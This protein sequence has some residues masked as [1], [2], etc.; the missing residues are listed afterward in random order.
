MEIIPITSQRQG[1]LLRQLQAEYPFVH[2]RVL[3]RT[4]GGREI[5]ALQV[6]KGTRRVL[7]TAGHHAN[8]YI[9]SMM[10]WNILSGYCEAVR[11]SGG[12]GGEQAAELYENC[13]LYAV[14]LVNP[15]GVDLVNGAVDGETYRKAEQI[16]AGWPEIPFPRGWKSNLQGVDLNL[17]YPAGWDMARRI[18]AEKGFAKPAPRDYP[19]R[20]PLDQLETSALAS[21]TCEIRP[22]LVLAYHA[23]GREIYASYDGMELPESLQL[24]QEFAALSGYRAARVPPESDHAGFKDWF[25]QR[26]CRPG[27]TIEVGMGENPL[28]LDQLDPIC[29]ENIPILAHAMAQ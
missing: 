7:V 4:I 17:N 6:G 25:L 14:P 27:F 11:R 12:F 22:D 23:Q 28:P 9:T 29:R 18:K 19:G 13:T 15:D 1:Q 16:A 5:P 10:V 21:Y 20:S 2:S 3:T 24:A 8:E 26:F